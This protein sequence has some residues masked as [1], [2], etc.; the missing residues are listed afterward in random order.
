MGDKLKVSIRGRDTK[1]N[2]FFSN[3][4]IEKLR[5]AQEEVVWLLNRGYP[6]GSIINLVGGRYQFSSRQRAALQRA[7]CTYNL[8]EIRKEE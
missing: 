2:R 6:I 3:E 1:D 5:Y 4:A 7:S 8:L